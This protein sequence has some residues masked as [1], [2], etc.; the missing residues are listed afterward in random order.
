MVRFNL[1]LAIPFPLSPVRLIEANPLIDPRSPPPPPPPVVVVVVVMVV[2]AFSAATGFLAQSIRPA[3]AE[4]QQVLV[5]ALR[6]M[7]QAP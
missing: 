7:N 4:L 5:Q 6:P 1:P 2:V 3:L